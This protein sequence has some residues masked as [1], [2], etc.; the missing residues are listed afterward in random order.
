[1]CARLCVLPL[2]L[3][4]QL[5]KMTT[6]Q[7]TSDLLRD[8]ELTRKE[9]DLYRCRETKP[10]PTSSTPNNISTASLI[11]AEDQLLR[12]NLHLPAGCTPTQSAPQQ[13]PNKGPSAKRPP[14]LGKVSLGKPCPL[15]GHGVSLLHPPTD[16]RRGTSLPWWTLEKTWGWT[17]QCWNRTLLTNV[18]GKPYLD[19]GWMCQFPR[20]PTYSS[21]QTLS[22]G[23]WT[24]LSIQEPQR[25]SGCLE[26]CRHS[27]WSPSSSKLDLRQQKRGQLCGILANEG[28]CASQC[29]WNTPLTTDSCACN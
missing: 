8:L 25:T 16:H 27:T 5:L 13:G 23:I 26:V 11:P 28:P 24:Q 3:M 2:S 7:T 10:G 4:F 9:R 15:K 22:F 14:F 17:H 29:K 18:L 12:S 20:H 1:M 19:D 6:S 21:C